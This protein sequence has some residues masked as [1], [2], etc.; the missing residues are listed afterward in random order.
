M[1]LVEIDE[2]ELAQ[3]RKLHGT[4]Q[5]II[6]HSPKAAA[7]LEQAHK[8]V[9]PNTP[10][11][12]LDRLKEQEAPID[13]IRKTLAEIK[14]EREADKAEREKREKLDAIGGKVEADL[15]R[16]RRSGWMDDAVEGVRKVMTDKGIVDVMDAA[17]LYERDNPPSN[18]ATPS[19]QGA[20]K[21]FDGVGDGEV[22][23]KKMIESQGANES[24][25]DKMVQ[26]TLRDIR[27]Q[28]AA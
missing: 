22:D 2:A 6:R 21:F 13:E 4:V 20:W 10:T 8:M 5:T 15:A 24:L 12:I 7:L 27:G 1:P 28:R 23:L 17:T 9:D 11:P 3:Y 26:D 19:G 25:T 16:L 14:A 18:V